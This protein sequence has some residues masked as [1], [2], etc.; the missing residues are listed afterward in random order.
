MGIGAS[1]G[2]MAGWLVFPFV[3][4][5]PFR[6]VQ[7][8]ALPAGFLAAFVGFTILPEHWLRAPDGESTGLPG[9]VVNYLLCFFA[10]Y[11]GLTWTRNRRL[12]A[13]APPRKE[14]SHQDRSAP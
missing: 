1:L 9:A 4:W 13:D 11:G 8:L 2:V 5:R 10:V 3:A 7:L 12:R 6:A 14:P